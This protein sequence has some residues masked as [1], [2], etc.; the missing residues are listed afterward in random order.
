[1]LIF[2]LMYFGSILLRVKNRL[3]PEK[4]ERKIQ[5]ITVS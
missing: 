2:D 1:M 5:V 4:Q 3:D